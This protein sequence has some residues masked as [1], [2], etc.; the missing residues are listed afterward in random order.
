VVQHLELV[1]NPDILASVA[2]LPKPPFCVGFAAES[3]NL[4][5]FAEQKRRNKHLP[6]L[7]ANLVQDGFGGDDNT[8]VLLDDNGTHPLPTASK[9]K[10]ARQLLQHMASMLGK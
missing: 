9:L 1:Q 2:S 7:A 5:E 10:L 8:L 6:L 3:E 4:L